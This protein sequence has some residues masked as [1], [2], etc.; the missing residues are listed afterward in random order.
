MAEIAD[1]LSSDVLAELSERG[2]AIYNERLRATLEPEFSRQFGAIQ[3]D[4]GDYAVA[5]HSSL[6]SR[7]LRERHPEGSVAAIQNLDAA[8]RVLPSFGRIGSNRVEC[9]SRLVCGNG[10]GGKRSLRANFLLARTGLLC[11]HC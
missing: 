2:M 6:A 4:S 1:V 11:Y 5:R 10:H 9:R 7:L 8:T 3:R